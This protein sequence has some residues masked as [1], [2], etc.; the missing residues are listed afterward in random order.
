MLTN[1]FVQPYFTAERVKEYSDAVA[2][3][4]GMD[5][6]IWDFIDGTV[7]RI[8]RPD[9]HQRAFYNGLKRTH[10]LKFQVVTT[11]D[12]LITHLHGPVESR[13]VRPLLFH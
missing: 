13:Q 2:R 4:V 12:G 6:H 10:A 8:C 7:R 9:Q 1:P 5:L 11:P 3:K